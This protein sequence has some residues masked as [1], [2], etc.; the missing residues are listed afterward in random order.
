SPRA[1]QVLAKLL[2]ANPAPNL[3]ALG[4]SRAVVKPLVRIK[5]AA[6]AYPPYPL[7]AA[8]LQLI[9]REG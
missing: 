6:K 1:A 5:L 7:E 3:R 4:L 2:R 8:L 9:D